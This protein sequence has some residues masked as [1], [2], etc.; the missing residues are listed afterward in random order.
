M[1]IV[2]TVGNKYKEQN[3]E[4]GHNLTT[5]TIIVCL[6]DSAFAFDPN[7]DNYYSD[8]SGDEIATGNGYTQNNEALISVAV[9]INAT[10]NLARIDCDNVTWLATG[11]SIATTG[12]VIFYNTSHAS[13]TVILCAD[14]GTDYATANG[15]SFTIDFSNGL[16]TGT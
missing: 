3:F 11:G 2:T 8:I 9:S 6:M 5:A 13:N 15:N 12:S 1:A 4:G 10:L 14:F 7:T 16:I